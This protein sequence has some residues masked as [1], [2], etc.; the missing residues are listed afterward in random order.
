MEGRSRSSGSW[1]RMATPIKRPRK[2]SM[3]VWSAALGPNFPMAGFGSHFSRLIPTSF[4]ELG[5][6]ISRGSTLDWSSAQYSAKDSRYGPTRDS[7]EEEDSSSEL[8]EA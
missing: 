7:W 2:P 5:H 1:E 3:S 8:S 4:T 6:F